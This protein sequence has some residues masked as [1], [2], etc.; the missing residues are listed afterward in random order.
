MCET[1]WGADY[2]QQEANPRYMAR[3]LCDELLR[4]YNLQVLHASEME[5]TVFNSEGKPLFGDGTLYIPQQFGLLEE[6]LLKI[7]QY[8][9]KAGVPI[10]TLQTEFG[11]GQLEVVMKPTFG[12]EGADNEFLLKN[13]IKEMMQKDGEYARATFMSRPLKDKVG[14]SNHYNHSLWWT[15]DDGSIEDAMYDPNSEHGLSK[16]AEHWLA[17]ILKHAPAIAAIA[18]PTVN[19][20][21]RL[22][23]NGGTRDIGTPHAITWG[24]EAR[25]CMVRVLARGAGGATYFENRL[26]GAAMNSY[27]GLA[28]TVAAGLDGLKNGLTLPP[29]GTA[30][31]FNG[32][33][34]MT[35]DGAL[36]ALEK[37]KELT[38]YLGQEFVDWFVDVKRK[39][40]DILNE[41]TKEMG[42]AFKAEMDFYS[43]WI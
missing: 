16:T 11:P 40:I 18:C 34:P 33:L 41:R 3:R 20:W 4:D 14:N 36:T 23:A 29:A 43:K 17:G 39:E 12:I 27:L 5:F 38:E 15:K 2:V 26:P 13:A 37:D 9:E 8:L 28:V 35:L 22:H 42:D 6:E 30:E 19:C 21:R 1:F 32:L 24:V 25:L 10:E 7:S 31:N